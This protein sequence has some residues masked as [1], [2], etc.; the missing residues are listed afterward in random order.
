MEEFDTLLSQIIDSTL[1]IRCKSSGYQYSEIIRS[2]MCVYFCGS[3]CIKDI[4][5]H[6]LPCLSQ[7]PSL[8]ACSADTIQRAINEL[9]EPYINYK[10]DSKKNDFNVANKLN[11]LLING[12]TV[13]SQLARD[14]EYD[15]ELV[16]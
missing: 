2:L 15:F 12:L 14:K 13:T 11:N 5:F 6:L 16:H 4:T 8:R 3:T 9:A 1:G 10:L 7:H